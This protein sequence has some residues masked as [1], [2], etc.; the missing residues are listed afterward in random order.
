MAS[1]PGE[2]S[3][4]PAS[5]RDEHGVFVFHAACCA[6][7]DGNRQT[8]T[9][10]R[11]EDNDPVFHSLP[12]AKKRPIKSKAG[13][14]KD[15]PPRVVCKACTQVEMV[16]E[17]EYD[18]A[19]EDNICDPDVTHLNGKPATEIINALEIKGELFCAARGKEI[20]V[21]IHNF[22]IRVCFGVEGHC[23]WIPTDVYHTMLAEGAVGRGTK[24]QTFLVPSNCRSGPAGNIQ[25]L[26]MQAAFVRPDWTLVFVDH[27]VMITFHIM[28]LKRAILSSDLEPGSSLWPI[29]WSSTHGPVYSLEPMQALDALD[30]WRLTTIAIE[31]STGIFLAVKGNQKVFNGYGAQETCDM[32]CSV[33]IQPCMP[34]YFVCVDDALWKRFRQGVIDYQLERLRLL[35]TKPFPYV[36]G[37]KPFRMNHDAHERFMKHVLCYRKQYVSVD[38]RILDAM[39]RR[40]LLNPRAVIQSSGFAKVPDPSDFVTT[41]YKDTEMPS[42]PPKETRYS[43]IRL[44]NYIIDIPRGKSSNK[45]YH[46]YTP[47]AAVPGVEWWPSLNVMPMDH[48]VRNIFNATTLG[49]YS[50]SVFIQ[51][52]WTEKKVG[53]S[54]P[55]GCRP[56]EIVGASH[57]KRPLVSNIKNKEPAKKKRRNIL[58]NGPEN[59]E[60]S[61]L[62]TRTMRSGRKL[63][64]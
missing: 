52:A 7:V 40:E 49:P 3:K 1:R 62:N 63:V 30:R 53:G 56:L 23:F 47:I 34:A 14:R 60:P 54:K 9:L 33:L 43:R 19:V 8:A 10:H 58:A 26:S 36:S 22:L 61:E 18:D 41:F 31:S 59:C 13:R 11:C 48:D 39:H 4:L 32:L 57:R 37:S 21:A 6:Q 35:S 28:A 46:V 42:V 24:S 15:V 12:E 55:K 64:R 2:T 16:D 38:Q 27:N 25:Q 45:S 20:V 44:Q 5:H 50:F 29:L 17:E 51:A